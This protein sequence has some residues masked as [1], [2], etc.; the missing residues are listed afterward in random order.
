MAGATECFQVVEIVG[1]AALVER[2]DVVSLQ[3]ASAAAIN[4][5]PAVPLEGR[6]AYFGPAA[7]R[8]VLTVMAAQPGSRDRAAPDDPRRTVAI[9]AAG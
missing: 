7:G 3:A 1:S 5:T 9:G 8:K 4:A 2:R 6:A